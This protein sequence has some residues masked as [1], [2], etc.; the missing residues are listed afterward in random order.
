MSTKLPKIPFKA[1]DDFV[2]TITVTNKNSVAAL[3]TTLRE[4]S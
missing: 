2:L 3:T 1:G 4:Q